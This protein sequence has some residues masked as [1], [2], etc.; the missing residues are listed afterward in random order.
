MKNQKLA[1]RAYK[2]YQKFIQKE[3]ELLDELSGA[4]GEE[5]K[6]ISDKLVIAR[7]RTNDQARLI[8]RY[9]FGEE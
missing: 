6:K 5:I 4:K 9:V 1:E 2:D 7:K 3:N 8:V